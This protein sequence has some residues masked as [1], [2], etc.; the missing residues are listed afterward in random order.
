MIDR[1]MSPLVS[2]VIPVYNGSNYLKEAIESAL[3]Q[4]YENIEILVINDGS[5]DDNKT[6]DIA[7]SYGSKIKYL[8]KDNGGVSTALNLG[9]KNMKGDYFSWLSHDD[10]YMPDNISL[11]IKNIFGKPGVVSACKTGS[12]VNGFF[13]VPRKTE[14]ILIYNKP[15]DHWKNWI[16]GCSILV[17]K[18][19]IT[20]VGCL[21]EKNKNAQDTELILNILSKYEIHFMDIPLVYRRQHSEQGFQ[22]DIESGKRDSF[23]LFKKILEK[24]GIDFFTNGEENSKFRE[25]CLFLFLAW[26][27]QEDRR[28]GNNPI[29]KYILNSSVHKWGSLFNP[30]LFFLKTPFIFKQI[31]WRCS[32]CKRVASF[33]VK[34]IKEIF[35]V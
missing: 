1:Q 23:E 25:S 21:N 31:V 34:K 5:N 27:Y 2:I 29:P 12:L 17:S 8:Y 30:C 35:H 10:V 32:D 6:E 15:L 26:K 19:I 33:F 18:S 28:S 4:T 9:I 20:D 24:D 14:R 16:Y 13:Y 11:Q 7:K 22:V 3:A